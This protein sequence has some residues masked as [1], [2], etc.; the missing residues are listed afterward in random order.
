MDLNF[1]KWALILDEFKQLYFV[2]IVPYGM[3]YSILFY[4]KKKWKKQF[5]QSLKPH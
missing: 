4:S 2:V 3:S 1:I 5:Y